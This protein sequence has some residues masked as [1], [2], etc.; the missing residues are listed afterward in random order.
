MSVVVG[1]GRVKAV[2]WPRL[3]AA[4]VLPTVLLVMVALLTLTPVVT[5]L[6]AGF[7]DAPPGRPGVVSWE[8]IR[9]SVAVMSQPETWQ[10]LW[11]TV[12]LSTVR[13]VLALILAVVL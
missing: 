6:V 13:A 10:I 9:A 4:V 11:T 12:W 8:S 1:V 7:R 2:A 3:T 5:A